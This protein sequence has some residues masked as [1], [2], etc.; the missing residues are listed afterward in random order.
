MDEI[1][2]QHMIASDAKFQLLAN[3]LTKI[4][5]SFNE[6]PQGALPSNTIPNLREDIKVITTRSGITLAGTL[7]PSP[8][9]PS[10]SKEEKLLELANTPLNE[11]CSV[12]LLKKLP[13]KLGDLGKFL[14]PCDFSELEECLALADLGAS[15]NLMPLSVCPTPSSD[16]VVVSHSPSLT[17][18][19]D[20]EFLLEET[21][22][23]LAL[24]DSIP[25]EIDN[26]IY[27]SEGDILFLKKL[28]NDGP[29][30]DLPPKELKNDK[31]E[32]SK[33]SNE[34]PLELE[35][36]DLPP[37]LE[38]AFLEGTL[39]LPVIIAK[40]LK[41]EEKDQF[42]SH[43]DI[44]DLVPILRVSKKPL[45]SYNPIFDIQNEESDESKTET[46]MEEVQIPSSQ[47]TAQIPPP[48]GK[49]E[50]SLGWFCYLTRLPRW[51]PHGPTLVVTRGKSN[52]PLTRGN[53][54]RSVDTLTRP[55][56]VNNDVSCGSHFLLRGGG[57]PMI[58][59]HVAA[60]NDWYKVVRWQVAADDY[61][62]RLMIGKRFRGVGWLTNGRVPR[63]H[64]DKKWQL[65]DA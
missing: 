43:E 49:F 14:I 39:K 11:N 22:A 44:N 57:C 61:W 58:A 52:R 6:I 32:K 18:F 36:K 9:P 28:L 15:I 12:V 64:G 56:D 45:D 53:P 17:P 42:N 26:G 20:N 27:D 24:D 29:T 13:E 38:Y 62:W 37:H 65:S 35:L 3:Q 4:E 31:T 33:S 7:V 16:P 25:P 63:V 1:L 59:C 21:N 60:A 10:S 46:K 55:I 51:M 47:S 2:R 54:T 50:T 41:R 8:N 40:D 48:Y 5:K 34:E 19:G 23:F 30:K